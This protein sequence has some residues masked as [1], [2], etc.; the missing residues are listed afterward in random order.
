MAF[1]GCIWV[2]T[3][4]SVTI[5]RRALIKRFKHAFYHDLKGGSG[6]GQISPYSK[7]GTFAMAYFF[8]GGMG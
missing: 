6:V 2:G 7:D 4:V 1:S 5:C 8:F 3:G